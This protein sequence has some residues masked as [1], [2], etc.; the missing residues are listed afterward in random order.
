ME[1]K[2]SFSHEDQAKILEGHCQV[3]LPAPNGMKWKASMFSSRA[4]CELVKV[5]TQVPSPP[6]WQMG[7]PITPPSPVIEREG[8]EVFVTAENFPVIEN[9]EVAF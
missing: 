3:I 9:D 7:G 4:V 8:S 1:A 5:R 2:V 6:D